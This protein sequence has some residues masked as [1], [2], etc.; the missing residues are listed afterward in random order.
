MRSEIGIKI[1][2]GLIRSSFTIPAEK[3]ELKKVYDFKCHNIA[4]GPPNI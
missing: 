3:F 4:C 1:F 2:N